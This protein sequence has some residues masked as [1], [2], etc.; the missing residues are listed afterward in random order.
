MHRWEKLDYSC[1]DKDKDEKCCFIHKLLHINHMR[2][3][4]CNCDRVSEFKTTDELYALPVNVEQ[5]ILD[6]D[7]RT[8]MGR[9]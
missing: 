7:V 5:L 9:L 3:K 2:E 4:R 1:I 6:I 8:A